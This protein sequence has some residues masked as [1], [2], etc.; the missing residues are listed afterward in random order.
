[1]V[2]ARAASEDWGR[3]ECPAAQSPGPARSPAPGA[4]VA[5]EGGEEQS[6]QAGKYADF[7]AV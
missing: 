6:V 4:A 2:V 7:V 1:M 3:R 5:T